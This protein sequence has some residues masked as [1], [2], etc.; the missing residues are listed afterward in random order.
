MFLSWHSCPFSYYSL[1]YPFSSC[2]CRMEWMNG[3]K[4]QGIRWGG[5]AGVQTALQSKVEPRPSADNSYSCTQHLWH[6][7]WQYGV[8]KEW[9]RE[10]QSLHWT[11]ALLWFSSLLCSNNSVCCSP[12]P[13]LPPLLLMGL[14]VRK[15]LPWKQ[16]LQLHCTHGMKKVHHETKAICHHSGMEQQI[17]E[18]KSAAKIWLNVCKWKLGLIIWEW[19]ISQVPFSI[20]G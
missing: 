2:S 12:F 17:L 19:W 1:T 11:T 7:A 9:A 3:G 10:L 13:L 14:G 15:K 6:N 5:A 8:E 18:A 16:I 20:C 4:F